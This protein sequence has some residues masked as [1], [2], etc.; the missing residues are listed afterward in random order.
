MGWL[1]EKELFWGVFFFQPDCVRR[2]VVWMNFMLVRTFFGCDSEYQSSVTKK[3]LHAIFDWSILRN[4]F[5]FALSKRLAFVWNKNAWQFSL[6]HILI[7]LFN[8]YLF[9]FLFCFQRFFV[10]YIYL[11]IRPAKP[12]SHI[13]NHLMSNQCLSTIDVY[14]YTRAIFLLFFQI[15]ASFFTS[16]H[17]TAH[18]HSL[19]LFFT[20]APT[21]HFSVYTTTVHVHILFGSV[22]A[23]WRICITPYIYENI[24]N[25]NI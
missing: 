13:Y 5:N 3:N 16:P 4:R 9:V 21:L 12:H 8:L 19:S 11:L 7:Y 2:N 22:T 10:H 24:M 17:S 18:T 23:I 1:S 6:L 15:L 14:V 20:H 25:I